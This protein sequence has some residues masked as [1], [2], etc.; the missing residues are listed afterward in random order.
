MAGSDVSTCSKIL[1][2]EAK[3]ESL[4]AVRNVW[5][6]AEVFARDLGQA[7]GVADQISREKIQMVLCDLVETDCLGLEVL[8]QI[9]RVHPHLPLIAVLPDQDF[10]MALSAFRNGVDDVL[11]YPLDND[12]LLK[13]WDYVS[14]RA[15][16][17]TQLARTQ[18]AAKR[19]LDDLILLKAIGETTRSAEDLQKLLDRIVDLIQSA[20]DVEIA[21]LMLVDDE[22]DLRIR[23][24][25][26]LPADVLENVT[27]APG[28]GVSG[29]VLVQGEPVLIDDLST[30]G[31][32][33]LRGGV[34]RY[35]TG[36]L[37]SVPIRY[38]QLTMGVL[39]VN[40][41]R[42][43]EA[44]TGVDQE[45]LLT[46]AHQTALAIENMKLVGRLQGK[47]LEIE[48][49]HADLMKLHQNRTRFVCNLSHE[50]K[51]PLTSVL[52]FSDLL[53]NFFDQIET[54]KMREYIAGIYSEGKHLEHLLTGMLR[55]FSI[56]SGSEDWHWQSLSL[57]ECFTRVLHVHD[58]AIAELN[59][60]LQVAFPTDLMPLWGD[61]DK[62]ELLLEAL[63]DNAVKFNRQ[64]G[65]LSISAANLTLHGKPAVY[66]QIANQGQTVPRESADD[67]FQEYSQLGELDA[68]KPS[69]VGIGLATCR[70]IL[71][72]MHGEIFLEPVEDEGTSIGLLLPTTELTN[73]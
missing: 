17:D 24:A 65:R 25:C 9:R 4:A 63:V 19:S 12:A 13:S 34:A 16:I 5:S 10:A 45:L 66:L 11:I 69:G 32:F 41:K 3:P 46:I 67:I 70:A 62:L 61:Q 33:P 53:L 47:N 27:I 31:R 68:G 48:H 15:K 8:Q 56:D 6:N 1:L 23:S 72:Q 57:S 42:D 55:L 2:L 40:N 21:S 28:E 54:P 35:R 29:H 60:D 22:G 7:H 37:L 18:Q 64:G 59:L 51:T 36:S 71:R 26:G 44:F 50:L 39:N 73:D 20:L 30:D 52:G 49:A 14:S 58:V 43:G 38:Q